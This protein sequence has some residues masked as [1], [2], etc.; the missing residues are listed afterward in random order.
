LI[1]AGKSSFNSTLDAVNL[2]VHIAHQLR[3]ISSAVF[4][5]GQFI[6]VLS[7]NLLGSSCSLDIMTIAEF[8]SSLAASYEDAFAHNNGL[9][10]FLDKA[11]SLLPPQANVLDVG[12]GTG[13]PVASRL[14]AAGYN[15]VG[16]DIA[17]AMVQLCRK[18]VPNGRFEVADMRY[19]VHPNKDQLDSVSS[20]LSLFPLNREEMEEVIQK[21]CSWLKIGGL[22]CIVTMA[23]DDCHPKAIQKGCDVDGL[24]SREISNRFMGKDVINTLFTRAGWRHV[25]S[26]NNFEVVYE[27]MELFVPPKWADTDDEPHYFIIARKVS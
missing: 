17:P 10:N 12:C 22:L 8:Y 3:Y 9:A 20:V 15:I 1:R 24:C 16:I 14:D 11:M 25:L 13:N 7:L 5:K 23:A 21:W 26:R 19:Y 27:E 4:F 2:E 6:K 18:S